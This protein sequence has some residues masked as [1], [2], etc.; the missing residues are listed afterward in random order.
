MRRRC[1]FVTNAAVLNLLPNHFPELFDSGFVAPVE[2]PLF[3][4]FAADETGLRQNLEVFAR[5]RLAHP[6][7]ARDEDAAH[8]VADQ[9][10]IH[11]LGKMPD[12]IPEPL[13]NLKP[14][15]IGQRAKDKLRP[16]IDN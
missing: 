14:A 10:A 3:D 8:S 5:G 16:H 7:L 15:L 13:Q 11:L 4:S 1:R 6:E 12:R 2:R 9:V